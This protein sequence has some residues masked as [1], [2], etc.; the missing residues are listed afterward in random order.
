MQGSQSY[1]RSMCTRYTYDE[2]VDSARLSAGRSRYGLSRAAGYVSIIGWDPQSIHAALQF[3]R[4]SVICL[5][6]LSQEYVLCYAPSIYD[7]EII[8]KKDLNC[9]FY[10]EERVYLRR[11]H[12]LFSTRDMSISVLYYK[13]RRKIISVGT[14]CVAPNS[15]FGFLLS[16]VRLANTAT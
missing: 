10:I 5:L 8:F 9:G 1:S 16:G 11:V 13:H 7:L 14:Q 12:W 4:R 2:W 6:L 3:G 15:V